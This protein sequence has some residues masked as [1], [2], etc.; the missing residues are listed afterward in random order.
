MPHDSLNKVLGKLLNNSL[1]LCYTLFY[2]MP[3]ITIYPN[4]LIT[5][6]K[7]VIFR[8]KNKLAD[9]LYLRAFLNGVIS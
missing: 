3:Y 5:I 1:Q 9:Y 7:E 8:Y 2:L 6:G 4:Y